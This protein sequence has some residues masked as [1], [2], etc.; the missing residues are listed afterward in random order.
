[1]DEEAEENN[2]QEKEEEEKKTIIE[3]N[4]LL[5]SSFKM[6]ADWKYQGDFQPLQGVFEN[7][8][9]CN[10]KWGCHV[11]L[12]RGEVRHLRDCL[13]AEKLAIFSLRFPHQIVFAR[14]DGGAVLRG[15]GSCRCF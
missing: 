12:M 14:E 2:K 8:R 1:M 13:E 5:C 7:N 4:R 15:E 6:A 3:E 9:P 11:I 10:R